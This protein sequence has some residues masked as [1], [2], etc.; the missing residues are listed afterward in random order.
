MFVETSC[1]THRYGSEM[2]QSVVLAKASTAAKLLGAVRISVG[3]GALLSPRRA[4][5]PW[6]GQDE[7]RRSSVRVFAR[8]LGGRDLALGAAALAAAS[9]QELKRVCVLGALAD[10]MDFLATLRDFPRLPRVGRW[11]VLSSTFGAAFSGATCAA[12]LHRRPSTTD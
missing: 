12:L 1:P 4:S 10:G 7:S 2:Q 11:L 5:A 9:D 8:A 3:L 6:L